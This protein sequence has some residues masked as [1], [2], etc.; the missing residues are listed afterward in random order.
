MVADPDLVNFLRALVAEE[1]GTLDSARSLDLHQACNEIRTPASG[2]GELSIHA[3]CS[4]LQIRIWVYG[5]KNSVLHRF[6]NSC[7]HLM[8]GESSPTR[9]LITLM[10]SPGHFD[11]LLPSAF[12]LSSCDTEGGVE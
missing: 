3:I 4:L 5:T 2:G 1:V 11:L 7:D 9:P 12:L 8:Y 10:H 6:V